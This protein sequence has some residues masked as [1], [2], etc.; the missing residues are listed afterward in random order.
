MRE[1]LATCINHAVFNA[2]I[3]WYI[4]INTNETCKL[5][6]QDE[7]K[8]MHAVRMY[9]ASNPSSFSPMQ[10]CETKSGTE[11]LGSRLV[12][13]Y[14]DNV[15]NIT[16]NSSWLVSYIMLQHTPTFLVTHSCSWGKYTYLK[17][18][19]KLLPLV[20]YRLTAHLGHCCMLSSL[21]TSRCNYATSHN[22]I[23][24]VDACFCVHVFPGNIMI[25]FQSVNTTT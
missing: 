25:T 5:L 2:H 18:N 7:V 17:H 24:R 3:Y 16:F 15:L 22:Y 10:S 20:G 19:N 1:E 14:S 8:V 21:I 11:S 12:C 4:N 6:M 9:L 13:T 23:K